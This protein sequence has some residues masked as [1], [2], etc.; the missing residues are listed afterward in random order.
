MVYQSVGTNGSWFLVQF[1]LESLYKYILNVRYI[2]INFEF[3]CCCCYC[4]SW[5]I[6]I[7]ESTYERVYIRFSYTVYIFACIQHLENFL[8]SK[9]QILKL[10]Y[11]SFYNMNFIILFLYI[12]TS[13]PYMQFPSLAFPFHSNIPFF[14]LILIVLLLLLLW[15]IARPFRPKWDRIQFYL[16]VHNIYM[17]SFLQ[18]Y[19]EAGRRV[20]VG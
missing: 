17:L 15:I 4:C 19:L 13:H 18:K 2:T 5:Y 3:V 6:Q 8:F 20:V 7:E 16:F 1:S 10:L 9:I 11:S 12:C 14:I